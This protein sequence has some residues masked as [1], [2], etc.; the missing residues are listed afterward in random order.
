MVVINAQIHN[1]YDVTGTHEVTP[2]PTRTIRQSG[3]PLLHPAVGPPSPE[4]PRASLTPYARMILKIGIAF[5]LGRSPVH[6]T[7]LLTSFPPAS[8]A[9]AT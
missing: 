5:L 4:A 1:E 9:I 3:L 2:S 7:P 6:L 8:A